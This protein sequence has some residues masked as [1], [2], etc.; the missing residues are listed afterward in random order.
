MAKCFLFKGKLEESVFGLGSIQQSILTEAQFQSMMG[1]GW[2]AMKGQSIAGSL[3]DKTFGI[4]TLPDA[5]SRFLRNSDAADTNLRGL[6]ADTTK[7]NGLALTGNVAGGTASISGTQSYASTNHSHYEGDLKAAI[8]A[9]G[10]NASVLTYP[11]TS[12]SSRGPSSA[13]NYTVTGAGVITTSR[14]FN[15]YTPVYGE[16]AGPNGTGSFVLNNTAANNGTL[17]IGA[18]DAETAPKHI[19]VNTFVKIN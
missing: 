6:V 18:G 16:T 7:K 4:S 13:S 17:A 9:S 15:H 2:V 1:T 14:A 3:L 12:V 11:A 10:G 8:G 5:R 19:I